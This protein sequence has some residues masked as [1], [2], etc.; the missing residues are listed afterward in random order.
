MPSSSWNRRLRVRA[1]APIVRPSSASGVLSSGLLVQHLGDGRS[2]SSVGSGRCRGCSGASWSSSTRTRRRRA[3]AAAV[4][5]AFCGVVVAW[6]GEGEQDLAGE[7]GGGE[8]GGMVGY[9]PGE[10]RREEHDPH[11]GVAVGAVVVRVPGGGPGDAVGGNDR[12]ATLGVHRQHAAGRVH[13]VPT[14]DG[15][16]PG[17]FPPTATDAPRRT[18]TA[19]RPDREGWRPMGISW[20]STGGRPRRRLRR[21]CEA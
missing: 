12:C 4:E 14:R 5:G 6:A 21:Q 8:H 18:A 15:T 10:G 3:R 2:R 11:V 20:H 17:S 19:G 7:V 13:Q 1:L 9:E 16:A